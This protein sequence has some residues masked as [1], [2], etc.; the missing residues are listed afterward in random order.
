MINGFHPRDLGFEARKF[1]KSV[2]RALNLHVPS[3][4]SVRIVFSLKLSAKKS[5]PGTVHARGSR[6]SSLKCFKIGHFN[7]KWTSSSTSFGQNGQTLSSRSTPSCLPVSMAS[8][9]FESRNLVTCWRI[10]MFL[11]SVRYFSLPFTVLKILYV[12]SLLEFFC[13]S[14]KEVAWKLSYSRSYTFLKTKGYSQT[15]LSTCYKGIY[16]GK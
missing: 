16:I 12:L 4:T 6:Y 1:L 5:K 15:G 10:E 11:I 13:I 7:R 3:S 8:L 14:P 2:A 9:W